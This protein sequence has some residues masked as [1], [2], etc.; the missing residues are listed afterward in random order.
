MTDTSADATRK[1]LATK[2]A[3]VTHTRAAARQARQSAA[4][5]ALAAAKAKVSAT[6]QEEACTPPKL[7][8]FKL[9]HAVCHAVPAGSATRAAGVEFPTFLA[10]LVNLKRVSQQSVGLQGV[11]LPPCMG[12]D[13]VRVM[14]ARP[15]VLH[16]EH[17]PLYW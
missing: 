1:A 4:A 17:A 9:R 2:P 10:P 7:R 11:M 15:L 8:L 6:L 12:A 13:Q 3:V 5:A 14:I 16:Q